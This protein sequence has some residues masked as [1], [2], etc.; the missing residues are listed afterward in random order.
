MKEKRN[1]GVFFGFAPQVIATGIVVY[2]GMFAV[3]M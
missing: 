2:I 3:R 1:R